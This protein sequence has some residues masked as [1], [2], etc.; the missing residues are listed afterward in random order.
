MLFKDYTHT[1]THTHTPHTH[2]HTHTHTQSDI[3]G[4]NS[5]LNSN[6]NVSLCE[7]SHV[8]LNKVMF[9]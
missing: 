2:T 1:H 8:Y 9:I 5:S 4:C 6:M 3:M 7:Q